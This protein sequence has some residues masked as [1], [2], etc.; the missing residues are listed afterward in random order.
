MA[1]EKATD[2]AGQGKKELRVSEEEFERLSFRIDDRARVLFTLLMV[3]S[4]DEDGN[5]GREGGFKYG[6]GKDF[7]DRVPELR[8]LG[9]LAAEIVDDA[10]ALMAMI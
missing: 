10:G 8:A 5:D 6:L 1:E 2:E 3:R 7:A 9:M 4:H